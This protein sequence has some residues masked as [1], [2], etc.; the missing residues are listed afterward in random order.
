MKGCLLFRNCMHDAVKKKYVSTSITAINIVLGR[1]AY[2]VDDM[3]ILFY[4]L[5]YVLL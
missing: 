3:I 4:Q 2:I 1:V 5:L